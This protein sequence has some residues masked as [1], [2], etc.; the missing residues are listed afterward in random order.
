MGQKVKITSGEFWGK[1]LSAEFCRSALVLRHAY[2]GE[3][4]PFIVQKLT[5]TEEMFGA[6]L[7]TNQK[8]LDYICIAVFNVESPLF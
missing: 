7:D 5:L 3:K 6:P 4:C 2:L 1:L 8:P